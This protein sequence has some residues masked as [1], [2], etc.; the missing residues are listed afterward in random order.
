MKNEIVISDVVHG[1]FNSGGTIDG[2]Y[3]DIVWKIKIEG[4]TS[5]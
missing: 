1:I 3:N 2:L 4:G 5:I